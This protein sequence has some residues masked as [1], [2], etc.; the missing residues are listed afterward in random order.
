[1]ADR[2]V[3]AIREDHDVVRFVQIDCLDG[4]RPYARVQAAPRQIPAGEVHDFFGLVKSG[5]CITKADQRKQVASRSAAHD[6]HAVR[7]TEDVIIESPLPLEQANI[8]VLHGRAEAR[9]PDEACR[10]QI[11]FSQEPCG[12]IERRIGGCVER[13]SG[14]AVK[15]VRAAEQEIV[16]KRAHASGRRKRLCVR[17][18]K[19]LTKAI[20]RRNH[21]G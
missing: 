20:E 8:G 17:H 18:W 13:G 21:T 3:T 4:G 16:R 15:C 1:V 5:D 9:P 14:R 6:Q 7:E 2:R 12:D 19:I 10:T 11:V